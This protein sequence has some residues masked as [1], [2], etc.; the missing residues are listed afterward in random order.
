MQ[1]G[2]ENGAFKSAVLT[3]AC[4]EDVMMRDVFIIGSKGIPASYGGFETFVDNLVKY[5]QSIE[6]KYHIACITGQEK[7]YEYAG[8]HCFV[9]SVPNI[10]PAKAVYYDI[11]AFRY[12]IQYIRRHKCNNPIVYVLACR[13]GPFV[14]VLNHSLERLGGTLLVNPDGHE[15]LRAKWNWAIKKYWKL[16]ERLMVK[17]AELLVCDSLNIETYIQNEYKKYRPQTTYIAYGAAVEDI[18]DQTISK[19]ARE[20]YNAHGLQPREY[21]LIVGRFVPENN[22]EL[23]ITEFMHSNTQYNLAIITNVEQNKFYQILKE[24]TGFEKD[25]RIRFVGTVYNQALLAEIRRNAIAYIHGHAVGGTNPS[26]LEAL[27][28]TQVN[29]L[30][31][32]SFNREVGQDA[33][34]YFT[35]DVGSMIESMMEIEALTDENREQIGQKAKHRIRSAFSH[36]KIVDEYEQLF[37]GIGR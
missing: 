28:A 18:K 4:Y 23:M 24:K 37:R 15:W 8:A 11:A 31:D 13:I 12:C 33:A 25:D 9:I 32:V 6:I 3:I 7:E 35:S 5:Q 36:E 1:N 29:L 30:Y 16:S 26:L 10:G 17:N 21:Y 2:R 27:A 19:E 34:Y 20:W 14:G 22:Y